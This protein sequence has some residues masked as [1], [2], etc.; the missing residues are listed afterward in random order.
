MGSIVQGVFGG[1]KSK[2]SNK[3]YDQ[4]NS[5]FSP[6]E[7]Q[8]GTGANALASLLSGDASGFNNFKAATG[9]DGAAEAGSRGI[10]G[11]A[12]ASG[13]LRSGSTG[14]ALEN[15]G[16]GLQNQYSN[17]YM[18]H[19]LQQAQLGLGAG[20]LISGAGQ[21]TKSSDKPGIFNAGSALG[22][23]GGLGTFA[24]ALL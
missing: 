13:L 18:N 6:L 3:A 7:A 12:A 22:K 10:T 21:V 2:T 19:L 11:N 4:L 16:V 14:K 24:G 5:T 23:G 15:Y 9:F 8:A 17:D 20:Q 1:K